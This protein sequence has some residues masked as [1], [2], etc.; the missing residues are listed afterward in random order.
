MD[1]LFT[2]TGFVLDGEGTFSNDNLYDLCFM[3]LERGASATEMFLKLVADGF[4]S[5]LM[6]STGLE[7]ERDKVEPDFDRSSL[8]EI[9]SQVPFAIGS[10]F[11]DWKWVR[12]QMNALLEIYRK[13]IASF[14]GSVDLYLRNRD[15]TLSMPTRIYFHLVI[16]PNGESPFAFMATYTTADGEGGVHHY[17][18]RY[19]LSQ[20]GDNLEAFSALIA[21]VSRLS[22][23]SDFI[24]SLVEN[25]EIFHPL[26]FTQEE[27]DRFLHEVDMYQEAGIVCR[28]PDFWKRRGWSTSVS[29]TVGR[30]VLTL[31]TI[32]AIRPALVY[33]GVPVTRE[34]I[35]ELLK[36]TSGLAFLKGRWVEVDKDRLKALLETGDLFGEQMSAANLVRYSAGIDKAAVKIS[37]P[38]RNWLAKTLESIAGSCSLPE[39]FNATLR[40]YQV[41]GYRYLEGMH[42]LGLGVCLADDMGLGKTVQVLSHLEKMREE[43]R[44][45]RVL[46]VVPSSLIGNWES[47][48]A[49]FAPSISYDIYHGSARCLQ[50]CWLTITTY[51]IAARDENLT[52]M[53]WDEIILDEAQYIKNP[54]TKASKALRAMKRKHSVILTGTPIENNLMNLWSL[55]D[56]ANEGLLG[57]KTGFAKYAK[58]IDL[59]SMS[60]LKA[61][62]AP[63]ILRR[64]KSDK[65]IIN[66]LP[67]KIETTISASLTKSQLVLYNSVVSQTEEV[68]TG[69][70]EA[71]AKGLVLSAIL[72]LKQICNHPDQY[73]GLDGYRS[74]DS[75]KFELLR[76]LCSTIAENRESVLVFTQFREIIPALD[77]LLASVFGR[78]GLVIDG[79]VSASKR[80]QLVRAFQNGNAPYMVLSLRAA[81][82]GLNLTKARNVIH[83]DRWWNPAV[84][85]QATD[86]AYRIGQKHK[87]VVYKFVTRDTVE[88]KI[89]EMI[90][91]KSSLADSIL[92]DLSSDIL[93]KLSA[94]EIVQAMKFTG[95]AR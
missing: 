62:I 40:P 18:L 24:R 34:E 66:D 21:P 88:E 63:F 52:A 93:T 30:P 87:V 26:N 13:E 81:G 4:L 22:R 37:F 86:R 85:N 36:S 67:D 5:A 75:G 17:P 8:E 70:D 94:K 71:Q 74:A 44:D 41:E 6:S 91:L 46:L 84:E 25:G 72:K 43:R 80:T 79:S 48:M 32:L 90:R 51:G 19:A 11:V 35:A 7:L 82:V 59:G 76:E 65:S 95:G 56:W 53:E 27:A 2:E 78:E 12:R 29:V 77:S 49:K 20:Y 92:G 39:D 58:D 61:A 54:S 55:M 3:P 64:L 33:E 45:A 31:G 42:K 83:F 69:K 23:S 10:G 57:T 14:S 50:K 16:N 38:Q 73:N 9:A 68:I 47:E 1:F 28:I 15:S 60:R 89:D